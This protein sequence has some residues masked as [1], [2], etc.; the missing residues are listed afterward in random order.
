LARQDIDEEARKGVVPPGAADLAGLLIDREIDARAF[1]GLGHE[2]P[3]HSGAG[4]DDAKIPISHPASQN[5]SA[6]V[7]LNRPPQ[8]RQPGMLLP[9]SLSPP[10]S[11]RGNL[12]WIK[13]PARLP[14]HSSC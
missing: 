4:D 12:I 7:H 10:S 2:Q 6:E 14:E 3:R 5:P 11:A 8:A 13:E 9:P 1:Q